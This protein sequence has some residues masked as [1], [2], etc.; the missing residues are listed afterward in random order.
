[1]KKALLIICIV[2]IGMSAHSQEIREYDLEMQAKHA[3]RK[4]YDPTYR[5]NYFENIIIRTELTSDIASVRFFNGSNGLDIE[6][7]PIADYQLGISFDYKWIG[8]GI[9]FAPRFLYNDDYTNASDVGAVS[10][11]INFFY[12]DRWRQELRYESVNGFF[13]VN[14]T[15][16]L[17][18][19]NIFGDMK[20]QR[21]IGRTF[22]IANP[23]FSFRASIT[24]G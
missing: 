10:A 3:E 1:M 17:S 16:V 22:F 5:V 18:D 13:T 11:S 8:L 24:M 15:P 2:V 9:S 20:S 7:R 12:S 23:N 19:E 14:P 4:G 6:L 21:F